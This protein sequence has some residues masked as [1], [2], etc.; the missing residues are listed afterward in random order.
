[1]N[2]EEITNLSNLSLRLL[3][4]FL[5]VYSNYSLYL[6]DGIYFEILSSN[7]FSKTAYLVLIEEIYG[8]MG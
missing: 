2:F 3:E 5:S 8:E 6:Q 7:L 4:H 1:M